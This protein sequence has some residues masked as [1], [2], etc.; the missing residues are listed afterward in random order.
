MKN[1]DWMPTREQ[2]LLDLVNRWI[3]NFQST[4]FDWR[5]E[6]I[7]GVSTEIT[8]FITLRDT[9]LG[10]RTHHNRIRKDEVKR[11]CVTAMRKFANNFIRFNPKMNAAD[12]LAFG[13]RER[14]AVPLR[15][16]C[17]QD[18]PRADVSYPGPG[19]LML[20]YGY[21]EGTSRGEAAEYRIKTAWGLMPPGV[22]AQPPSGEY[23]FTSPPLHGS[24]LPNSV[25]T[26]RRKHQFDFTPYSQYKVFFSLRYENDKGQEGPCSPVFS[27]VIP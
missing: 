22:L 9:F 20:H 15:V 12:K 27:A 4:D 13:V 1:R 3:A 21:R 11:D 8:E 25:N 23:F 24:Q 26:R 6:D 17:P 10:N 16:A 14:N 7:L 2:D 18:I 19:L 5:T